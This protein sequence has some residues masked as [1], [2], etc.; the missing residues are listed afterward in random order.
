MTSRTIF[1]LGVCL[2]ATALALW[3]NIT[4]WWGSEPNA[5]IPT[6][7]AD[8]LVI[9]DGATNRFYTYHGAKM[10]A[11][12]GSVMRV[13]EYKWSNDVSP[14]H[15]QIKDAEE[16]RRLT[17]TNNPPFRVIDAEAQRVINELV[18]TTGMSPEDATRL[19][20][21]SWLYAKRERT[22]R[23]AMPGVRTNIDEKKWPLFQDE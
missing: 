1:I 11:K 13:P 19:Y 21:E 3:L 23:P 12:S 6:N 10:F 17:S 2:F 14:A 5:V 4:F 22:N 18:E 20:E 7:A 16:I 15:L 8:I 9:Q